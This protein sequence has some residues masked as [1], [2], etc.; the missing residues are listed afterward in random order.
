MKSAYRRIP[1]LLCLAVLALC[2]LSGCGGKKD[3]PVTSLAQLNEA[4][5]R[6]GAVTNTSED[7]LVAQELPNAQIE[8]I[9]DEITGYTSVQQGKVDA[10]VYDK[11]SIRSAIHSGLHGVRLL[12]ETLGEGNIGAVAFLPETRIPELEDKINSFLR[13]LKADGTIDDMEQR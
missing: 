7:R 9:K 11:T 10:F 5:R 12:D 2:L 13:E 1:L 6:I 8:H 3:E 4:G